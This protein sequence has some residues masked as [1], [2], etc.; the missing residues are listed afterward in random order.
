MDR[1]VTPRPKHTAHNRYPVRSEGVSSAV[2][3]TDETGCYTRLN[4]RS[5]FVWKNFFLSA[6]LI[7]RSTAIR[8]SS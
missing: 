6:A 7:G 4:A 2:A 8:T 5:A 1:I 3:E